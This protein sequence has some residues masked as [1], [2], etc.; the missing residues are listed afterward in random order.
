M[1][2]RAIKKVT[3]KNARC[4][5][6][7]TGKDLVPSDAVFLPTYKDVI[8]CYQS[9]RLQIKGE[10]SKEPSSASV[11]AAVAKK[12]IDIWEERASIPVVSLK[13]VIGMILSYNCKYK[14][15]MKP[16]KSR[17]TPFLQSKIEKFKSD[18]ANLFDICACKCQ[19]LFSCNCEKRSKVP[20]REKQFLIDQRTV[21]KMA[22]AN[23]DRITTQKLQKREER[24]RRKMEIS[25]ALEKKE[26]SNSSTSGFQN[27]EYHN[28]LEDNERD[29]ESEA[30]TKNTDEDFKWSYPLSKKRKRTVKPKLTS[31]MR[32][33]MPHTA[34]ATDLTGASS[35][36]VAKISTAVLADFDLVSPEQQTYI[37]DKNKVRREVNKIRKELRENDLRVLEGTPI[38]S[39]YFDGRKDE[40]FQQISGHR[41][42]TS[43]AHV[44]LIEEPGSKYIGHI[45]LTAGESAKEIAQGI[46][47]F[48]KAYNMSF[49][50]LS[51]IGCDGTNV[52]T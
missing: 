36:S 5:L 17:N 22:I 35:R 20:E 27:K 51:V 42:L 23:V 43:E 12:V 40:T 9:T 50:N 6:F 47:K 4:P 41:K 29:L 37:V 2:K 28:T 11:A 8:R 1:E 46:I 15:V 34:L 21:R 33:S 31:Q 19:D 10:G 45:S 39:L 32:I 13:R 24:V 49:Q 48:T 7:G 38:K 14:N 3:R 52:N 44:A 30:D 25:V 26:I 16:F 18:A